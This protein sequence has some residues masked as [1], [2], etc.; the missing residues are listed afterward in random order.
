M[1]QVG[2]GQEEWYPWGNESSHSQGAFRRRPHPAR[3]ALRAQTWHSSGGHPRPRG[4]WGTCLVGTLGGGTGGC[5]WRVGARVPA[6]P[7]QRAEPRLLGSIGSISPQRHLHLLKTL[8][9]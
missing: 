2:S 7:D 1:A 5:L 8:G 6:G 4:R 9:G 3:P